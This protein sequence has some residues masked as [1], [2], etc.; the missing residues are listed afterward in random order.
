MEIFAEINTPRPYNKWGKGFWKKK[1]DFF[2]APN[3]GLGFQAFE[4]EQDLN[5]IQNPGP[6]FQ[7][8]L[9]DADG[10]SP[11]YTFGKHLFQ[12]I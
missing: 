3:P 7:D 4:K 11:S 12:S 10:K 5:L 6:G 1:E 9:N 2:W 8:K